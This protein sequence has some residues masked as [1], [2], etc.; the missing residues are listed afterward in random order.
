MFIYSRVRLLKMKTGDLVI[1]GVTRDHSKYRLDHPYLITI[2]DK[3]RK[4]GRI[5][6][7]YIFMHD[8]LVLGEDT[9]VEIPKAE[10]LLMYTP[11]SETL[12][13]YAKIKTESKMLS[14]VD[15]LQGLVDGFEEEMGCTGGD[16][17]IS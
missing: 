9:A 4:S 11:D 15:Q 10:V 3:V 2:M 17:N 13:L 5:E 1:A 6:G 12:K 7:Q 14:S 8:W 16:P